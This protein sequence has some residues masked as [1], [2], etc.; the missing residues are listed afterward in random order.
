VTPPT[1]DGCIDL[2]GHLGYEGRRFSSAS[3]NNTRDSKLAVI[4]RVQVPS[5]YSPLNYT[6]V[7]LLSNRSL[8]WQHIA[9]ANLRGKAG[10]PA[11]HNCTRSQAASSYHV[12][13]LREIFFS[14]TNVTATELHATPN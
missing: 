8:L 2:F 1:G 4:T 12:H 5:N 7:K 9:I 13:K 10:R 3:S 6:L 14:E 11:G